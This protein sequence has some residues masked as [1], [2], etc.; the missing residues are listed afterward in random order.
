MNDWRDD[1]PTIPADRI[2]D[3]AIREGTRRHQARL[4]RQQTVLYSGMGV[5]A[6]ALIVGFGALIATVSPGGD[7]DDDGAAS[8]AATA[9]ATETTGAPGTTGATGATSGAVGTTAGGGTATTAAAAG[10][11]AAP[12]TT[13]P[14]AE[15]TFPNYTTVG[16]PI[17]SLPP[18]DAVT[19]RPAEI[20]EE[21]TSG[22]GCGRLTAL[23]TFNPSTFTPKRPIVHWE[24]AG[25]QGEGA[26]RVVDGHADVTI[27]PF[28]ADTLEDGANHEVLIYV[29][30]AEAAG[31]EIFRAPTVILRDCSP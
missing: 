16:G 19:V 17:A 8:T 22:A 20:W 18:S 1:L 10:T 4:R 21:P 23:I 30:D 13:A 7:D 11:T 29:T 24:V 2:R 12:G 9:A 27:G 3:E 14:A 5:G 28:P 31:D 25:M 15:T 6:V 26:M